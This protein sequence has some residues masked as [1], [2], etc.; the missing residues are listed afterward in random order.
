MGLFKAMPNYPTPAWGATKV[1][2]G[3]FFGTS[4]YQ[5]G[6]EVLSPGAFGFGGL[7]RFEPAPNAG[8]N[9]NQFFAY[10]QNYY[11]VV[12]YPANSSSSTEQFAPTYAGRASNN[13]IIVRWF[14]ANN[15]EVANN[16]NL[17]AEAVPVTV[18]G[19]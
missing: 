4:N 1:T 2:R 3:D 14:A 8:N 11:A 9:I 18:F 15:A 19:I 6:G 5:A 10:S 7:E 17:A 12:Q 13:Q 16:T